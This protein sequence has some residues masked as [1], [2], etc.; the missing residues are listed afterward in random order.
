MITSDIPR[1]R[2]PFIVVEDGVYYAY[3][4][5]WLCYKNTSGNLHGP[6]VCLGTVASVADPARDGG[7]HW[8][9]EVHR[10]KGGYYMFTTYQNKET[11]RRGCTIMRSDSP[12]GPF[13]EISG[14][15]VTPA[16]W[17]SIDGTLYVDGEGQPWMVFVREWVSA[18]GGVGSFAAAKLSEDLTHF[19][20][21]PFELFKAN[22]PS[23]AAHTVTDGCFMHTTAEGDL[24]MLWSNFDVH[25]YVVALAKSSNGRLDGEWI[26]ADTLLYSKSMTGDYD[27][28]HGMIFTDTD[29]QAYVSFHSP[30]APVGDRRETPVF[31]A[32][33]EKDGRLVWAEDEK[34]D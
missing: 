18:P 30:N 16:E 11:G 8:A 20:S 5:D 9:P 28:G 24:L 31:L 17:D 14:G 23:W 29:G 6:W 4:T 13:C 22:E 19:I 25:G 33:E 21:E 12:E 2:D 32:I 1:L 3:G 7:N 10:Y 26:H 27:G 15:H 34:A